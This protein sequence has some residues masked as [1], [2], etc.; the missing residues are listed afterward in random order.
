LGLEGEEATQKAFSPA[1]S[2]TGTFSIVSSLPGSR[3]DIIIAPFENMEL[4]NVVEKQN[5]RKKQ[6]KNLHPKQKITKN[7]N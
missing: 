7:P 2:K 6:V 3:L 1:L 5:K 4:S